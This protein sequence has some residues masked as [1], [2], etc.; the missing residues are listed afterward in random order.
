MGVGLGMSGREKTGSD[1]SI[2]D[3]EEKQRENQEMYVLKKSKPEELE[4]KYYGYDNMSS[5]RKHEWKR[6][7]TGKERSWDMRMDYNSGTACAFT[8]PPSLE[9]GAEP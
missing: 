2:L 1:Q 4:I 9:L 8:A 5:S 3:Y 6:C 7:R